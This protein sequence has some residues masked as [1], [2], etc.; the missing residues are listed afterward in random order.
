MI[1]R[2]SIHRL[3]EVYDIREDCRL[4]LELT[5]ELI[6]LFK[7][8]GIETDAGERGL[9]PEDW[10]KFG[11]VIK[12]KTEFT[13]AYNEFKSKVLEFVKKCSIQ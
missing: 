1:D 6:S 5:P 4:A 11:A 12:T 9:K 2:D 10:P 3:T 8:V 7:E 13:N